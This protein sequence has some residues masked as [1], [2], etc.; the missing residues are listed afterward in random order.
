MQ[1]TWFCGM[2]RT[3]RTRLDATIRTRLDAP[4]AMIPRVYLLE[5]QASKQLAFYTALIPP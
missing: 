1:R 2:E 5:M 3:V 4:Y